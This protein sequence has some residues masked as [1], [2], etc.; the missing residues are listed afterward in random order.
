MGTVIVVC[1]LV[2]TACGASGGGAGRPIARSG[3]DSILEV[4][5][6]CQG[7]NAEVE[8]AVDHAYV[9]QTWIGCGGIGFA[10]ST[11]GGLSFGHPLTVPGSAGSGYYPSH[12]PKFGWDPAIAV[13]PDGTLYVSYMIE[14]NGYAHPVVAVSVNHGASLSKV[15]AIMPPNRNN[16]GDRDFITV[17]PT[18]A[19]YVTWDYG[20][21][22][23]TR[24]PNTVL[25][26]S[27]NGG[28]TWSHLVAVSPG[29]PAHGGGVAAPLVVEPGGR[30][31][32]LFWTLGGDGI[33]HPKLPDNHIY[34]TSSADGGRTW[35]KAVAVQ[36]AAGSIGRTVT[37]IDTALGIDPGGTLYATWDTQHP[38]GD[39]GWLSYSTD[40]G[41]TWSPARRVT[42]DHDNAEHIMA[43]VGG[44]RPGTAYVSW[45][46][47]DAPQG[48]AQYLRAFSVRAGWLSAPVRVS[49]KYGSLNTWPGDTIGISLLG[50]GGPHGPRVILSW[51]SAVNRHISQIWAARVTP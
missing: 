42:L 51:G 4:S 5:R 11:N 6:G 37:W 33:K 45:L 39:I 40:N 23:R 48:F 28:K 43:V 12:L 30:I 27:T 32:V 25:Q 9:Y 16:W 46:S 34:F 24:Y 17:A 36:P 38:G 2:V 15:S 44:P 49:R 50:N 22:I 18:G 21:S 10:R 47:N 35:S 8:E 7:Q 13:A 14:R 41:R 3:A 26:R 20:Q 1:A 19:L 29:F 31:D